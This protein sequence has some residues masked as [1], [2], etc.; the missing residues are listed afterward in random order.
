MSTKK[1]QNRKNRNRKC[2]EKKVCGGGGSLLLPADSNSHEIQL[3]IN[4]QAID[5]PIDELVASFI[6]NAGNTG[7]FSSLKK[8]RSRRKINGRSS[9]DIV[10]SARGSLF[11]LF[12]QIKYLSQ[13]YFC[14]I[15]YRLSICFNHRGMK[16]K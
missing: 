11:N 15:S 2:R 13:S 5:I 6:E 8:S 14:F 12:F 4:I 7:C 1:C 10:C 3:A 16:F 9:I